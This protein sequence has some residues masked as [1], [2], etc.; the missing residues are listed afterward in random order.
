MRGT[1]STDATVFGAYT[2]HS[3]FTLESAEVACNGLGGR[4]FPSARS[5]AKNGRERAGHVANVFLR[6][7]RCVHFYK[8]NGR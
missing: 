6:A 3:S 1:F 7:T 5:T 4:I 2:I 8:L